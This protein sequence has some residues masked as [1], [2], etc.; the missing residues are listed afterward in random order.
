MRH[1]KDKKNGMRVYIGLVSYLFSLILTLVTYKT[2]KSFGPIVIGLIE[3]SLIML[4]V[5]ISFKLGKVVANVVKAILLLLYNIQYGVLFFSGTFVSAIMLS[6]LK[7]VEALSG[8]KVPYITSLVLV[9]FF[10]FLPVKKISVPFKWQV[11][12]VTLGL[13]LELVLLHFVQ[14]SF[15]PTYSFY[16]VGREVYAQYELKQKIK[17]MPNYTKVFYRNKVANAI[18]KPTVLPNHPNIVVIFTEGLSQHIVDDSRNIMPNI[19]KLEKESLFFTNYFNHTFATYRGIQGQLFSGYQ[20]ENETPNDLVSIQSILK[21]KG[22]STTFINSEPKNATF[23]N[24]L[25]ELGFQHLIHS[26]KLDGEAQSVT[27]KDMY[28]YLF[29]QM[30][31]KGKSSQPFF[32]ATYTFGTHVSLDSPDEKFVGGSD[33]ELNKFYNLDYQFGKF[34]E[35]FNNSPL[36]KDTIL[37]FTSDHSTFVDSSYYASFPDYKRNQGM[38]DEVPLFIY[39][40]GI[41]P[42]TIDVKGENSLNLA[43]TIL[44]YI[45]VT[46]PNYFL[47]TSL[48]DQSNNSLFDTTFVSEGTV[49][50]T[51]GVT[52]GSGIKSLEPE[53]YAKLSNLISKYYAA[54]QQTPEV[55]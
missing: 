10:T 55:P 8:N 54:K 40:K 9:L 4:I 24:Y 34:I 16:G 50:S 26:D 13:G 33:A 48:L 53:Q 45:D 36:S 39:Y 22:Y 18:S 14:P 31:K 41:Q 30:E 29:N 25:S 5:N 38:V 46:A 2:T 19:A 51:K 17:A 32:I 15:S 47:G 3:L 21:D 35:K 37:V 11:G 52:D 20:L 23:T 7:S 12:L 42:Q 44:D 6:N 1:S 28:D 49:V 43:P 27:D